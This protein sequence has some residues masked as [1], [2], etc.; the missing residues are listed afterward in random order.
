MASEEQQAKAEAIRDFAAKGNLEEIDKMVKE[1]L[2]DVIWWINE[3]SSRGNTALQLAAMWG[4]VD[5]CQALLAAGA[6]KDKQSNV[7]EQRRVHPLPPPPHARVRLSWASAQR[8]GRPSG[9]SPFSLNFLHSLAAFVCQAGHTPLMCAAI[10]GGRSTVV[11]ELIKLGAD[12][13]KQDNVTALLLC[14]QPW[15]RFLSVSCR[16]RPPNRPEHPF[17]T[18][19][20]WL[21]RRTAGRHSTTPPVTATWS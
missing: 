20:R 4:H 3:G 13:N 12:V 5:C 8:Q 6:D 14:H 2:E 11:R 7:S 10:K 16:L 15:A 1:N 21:R 9:G 17:V 19:M 18:R